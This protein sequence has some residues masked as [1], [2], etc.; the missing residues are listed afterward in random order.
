VITMKLLP[1]YTEYFSVKKTFSQLKSKLNA[2]EMSKQ[3]IVKTFENQAAIDNISHV[4][5][6]DLVIED[7]DKGT[8]VSVEYSVVEPLVGN[9]SALVTFQ[10]STD[11]SATKAD[12]AAAAE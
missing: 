8:V 3:D 11:D 10:L 6:S 7:T 2:G 12:A 9:V 1:A 4:A 5:G